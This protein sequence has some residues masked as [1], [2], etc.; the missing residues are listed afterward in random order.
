[1]KPQ[2]LSSLDRFTLSAWRAANVLGW[3]ALSWAVAVAAHVALTIWLNSRASIGG[4]S[5]F[6]L[7]ARAGAED[8]IDD[9]IAKFGLRIALSILIGLLIGT[10]V[11]RRVWRRQAVLAAVAGLAY[12]LYVAVA[13]EYGSSVG[14]TEC[15]G[16]RCVDYFRSTVWWS[17]LAY[18][19]A[20]AGTIVFAA[21]W[22][23]RIARRRH[24]YAGAALLTP[25]SL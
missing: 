20:V 3:T 23:R 18:D 12:A 14:G 24:A 2:G 5:A 16:D 21:W 6:A 7:N 25:G 9:W 22:A 19:L 17:A 11:G 4:I 13:L 8:G 15:A 1:M 10:I